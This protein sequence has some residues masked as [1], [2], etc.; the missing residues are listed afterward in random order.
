MELYVTPLGRVPLPAILGVG[1]PVA[2]TVNEPAVPA[3]NAM[4]LVLVIVGAW[5]TVSVKF[6]VAFG[7]IPLLAV[8]VMLYVPPVPE[9]GVPLRTPVPAL[10]VTPLGSAPLSLNAGA[11]TPLAVTVKVPAIPTVKVVLLALVIAGA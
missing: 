6:W 2:V 5:F 10:K 3:V 1:N 8:K 4:L 9:A 11:G 7:L